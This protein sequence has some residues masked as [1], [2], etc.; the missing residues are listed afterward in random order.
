MV[1]GLAKDPGYINRYTVAL[2]GGVIRK[3]LIKQESEQGGWQK[4]KKKRKRLRNTRLE[5]K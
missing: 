2:W 1:C 5:K 4:E 3:K